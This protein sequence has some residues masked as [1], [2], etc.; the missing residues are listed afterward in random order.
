M[1]C[2]DALNRPTALTLIHQKIPMI[3]TDITVPANQFALGCLLEAYPDIKVELESLVPLQSGII[4]LFW[5]E[6][7]EHDAIE[8][9]LHNDPLTRD[10]QLLTEA[11]GRFLFE[12][13]WSA[14]VNHLVQPLLATDTEILV[15]E[16][17]VD[18]WEFRLQFPTRQAL[19]EFLAQCREH[20]VAIDL[21]RLYNPTL[22]DEGGQLTT[23]QRE[24]IT[25]AYERGFWNIPR[26]STLE[27]LA[28]ELGISGNS[29]SQ[30]LRRGITTLVAE[31]L[32]S[33]PKE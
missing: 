5:V 3:I 18:A 14:D 28:A 25:T 24:I 4:P 21:R 22:P 8:A 31:V 9:T 13:E 30:R 32:F 26:D 29:A 17:T 23:D 20:G 19:T 10:V 16:G 1:N 33:P 11:D 15:A 2:S 27:D 12:I 6:G 7:G